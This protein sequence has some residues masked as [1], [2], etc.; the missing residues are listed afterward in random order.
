MRRLPPLALVLAIAW[1]MPATS[2]GADPQDTRFLVFRLGAERQ[3]VRPDGTNVVVLKDDPRPSFSRDDRARLGLRPDALDTMALAPNGQRLA[4]LGR[5][6]DGRAVPTLGEGQVVLARPDG[7]E[8]KVLVA[9]AARRASLTWSPDGAQLAYHES[10][11][12]NADPAARVPRTLLRIEIVDVPSG[13]ARRSIAGTSDFSRPLFTGKGGLVYLAFRERVDKSQFFDIKYA[14]L[15][16]ANPANSNPAR[17]LVDRQFVLGFDVTA[18]ETMLAYTTPDGLFVRDLQGRGP[19]RRAWKTHDVGGQLGKEWVV[20]F[21]KPRWRPDGGAV[22]CRCVF[23]GGRFG[24]DGGPVNGEEDVVVFPLEGKP[25]T[26][27]FNP[28]WALEGWAS[29]AEVDR[30]KKP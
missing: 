8:A 4:L 20:C 2:P 1:G 15:A 18:D 13:V 14:P 28:R 17:G 5:V 22:A 9:Q 7:S 25:T 16:G 6:E 10:V 23:I 30:L 26:F 3:A 27:P 24:G 11:P 19:E 12:T 29:A 21:D